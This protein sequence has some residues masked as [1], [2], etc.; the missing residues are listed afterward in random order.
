[1]D[2]LLRVVAVVACLLLLFT[3][4][5]LSTCPERAATACT[6]EDHPI[7]F[8][9]KCSGANAKIDDIIRSLGQLN[10]QRLSIKG[11]SFPELGLLPHASIRSLHL[12][13]CGIKS[14][15]KNAF[16]ELADEL[17]ELVL[18]SNSLTSV[19]VL[20]SMPRLLSLNLNNNQL[21]DISEG[22]LEGVGNLRHLRI[23]RNKICALSRNALNESK[24]TLELLDLSDNCLTR[25]P[26]QNLRNCVR[27]MYVDLSQN[28]ITEIAN[29]E[30]MNL[31][32]LKELRVSS[33]QLANIAPM[34]F[35]NVPQ[36]QYL[37]LKNNVLESLESSRLFQVFKQLE[38][39]DLSRNRLTKVPSSK[40]LTNIRQIR[41]D[42][43]RI[44]RIETLAF[45]SNSKLRLISLQNNRI[46]TISRNSFDALEQLSIL[47]LANNSLKALERG[48][49]DGM[50]NLQQ[51]NLRNNSL[52]ELSN[53]TFTSV[54]LLTTL[55]LAHNALRTISK[56]TFA[57][58][59]KLFWLDLSSNHIR[60]FEKGAFIHRVGN[61]LLDGNPLHCDE[62]MDWMVEYLVL[63]QVRTFLPYQPE[64]A[65]SSPKKYA[66]VRLK[67]LMI[68]KA[69]ETI[70]IVGAHLNSNAAG[71][72]LLENLLPRG[73]SGLI[74]GLQ[75]P[76]TTNPLAGVP[77]IGAITESIPSLR[78]LPGLNFIPKVEGER[79]QEV[80]RLNSAIE[81]FS[82]PLIRLS[83]GGQPL[84]SDIEQ[85]VKSIPNLVV[86][87][88]G[89]GNIDITKLPPPVIAHVLRGGQ[90]PG[91]PKETMERIVR[92]FLQRMHTAA[93]AA[94]SGHPLPDEARYLPPLEKLPHELVA[95]VIKG[96]SLPY[97]DNEQ[98][99]AIT[100]Y[101]TARLP[102]AIANSK[103]RGFGIPPQLLE[104]LKLL[105]PGYD[106]RK[107]PKEVMESVGRGEIPDFNLLPSDLQQ[108]FVAN[109]Q[110][111]FSSFSNKPNITVEDILKSLPKFERPERPTF[112]PYDLNEVSSDLT[113]T[114]ADAEKQAR[115]HYYTAALLG[116]I[117]AIS[118]AVLSLLCVYMRR[119]RLAAIEADLDEDSLV[120]PWHFPPPRA[121]SSPKEV[122]THP[123]FLNENATPTRRNVSRP[124]QLQSHT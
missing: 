13:S 121:S 90:I 105:P 112:S 82:A 85:I 75:S 14:I 70:H 33:N 19:P 61:I 95:G 101:Y 97:L 63:H 93:A 52:M 53:A 77:V 115:M 29:F 76:E 40:E 113:H 23:E 67:D 104:M 110:R 3:D 122:L 59:K 9:V 25:I 68:K 4:K 21:N 62:K 8:Y 91:I 35:M 102:L 28:K 45:S 41:L 31:P 1:M 107:I 99:A 114:E 106:I 66:G 27:L 71:H 116:L 30:V 5:V 56:G 15:A 36:L 50:K 39:L 69:N 12:I 10:V 2:T 88:P 86:N 100:E 72:R 117:G 55:D 120:N 73:M 83:T 87:V 89:F 34:A 16:A 46:S 94:N 11:A 43:N 22:S 18:S 103:K 78:N 92:E 64:V 84:P 81:Q 17:E 80:Q 65:C 54:P 44:S 119:K 109:S 32:M 108:Y 49:L 111:L 37:Y 58:L 6:C 26:A 96:E 124:S 47:L 20:G 123:S 7:G 24:G 51:L 79:A 60:S 118:L 74:P 98:M 38:V 48:T 42:S 57:P